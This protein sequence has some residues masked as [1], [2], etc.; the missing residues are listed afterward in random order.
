[1]ATARC[2]TRGGVASFHPTQDQRDQR[3]STEHTVAGEVR[4]DETE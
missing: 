3:E 1:V 4:A 2:D